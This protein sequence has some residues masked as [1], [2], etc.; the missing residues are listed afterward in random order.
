[1]KT[2]KW[3]VI[4]AGGI[5][6]RRA[7]PAIKKDESFE[8]VAVMDRVA[9]TAKAIGEKYGVP[10]F[11]SEEEMLKTVKCDA[12]YIGTPVFCHY[13]QAMTALEYGVNV[14]IEKPI[15]MRADDARRL[16]DAFKERG[17]QI[18]V[19][20]MMK[21]HNL[22]VK[23]REL[24][25]SGSIGQVVSVSSKFATWYPDIAGAWRQ[26]KKLS[27]G[28][29]IMDLA[30]H[31]I[32]LIEYALDDEIVETKSFMHTRTFSYE[33]E[34]CATIIFKTR[35][36]VIG[37][38]D[39]SFNTPD[40]AAPSKLEIF[41]TAGSIICEGTLSQVEL[42]RLTYV[43]EP[44]KEYSPMLERKETERTVLEG[45]NGDMYLKQF[46]DFASALR[47]GKPNYYYSDR[48][49]QVQTVV[50]KIYDEK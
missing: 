8:L 22:H 2:I 28:G 45:E 44:Q 24:V 47:A 7:I 6:D 1:M 19:G 39:A 35:G 26:N 4:G 21:Y 36:G 34:D 15:T 13:E 42:G 17:L 43:Y 5:A 12:V 14:F 25:K 3:A 48:A 31:C 16:V 27:G 20:Y 37:N 23:A 18:T 32:E 10:Y 46:R 29:A 9:E 49:V 50:D 30:V 41:G 33:V 40:N 11:T 38:I